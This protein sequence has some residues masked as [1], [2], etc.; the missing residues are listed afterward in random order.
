MA[1]ERDEWEKDYKGAIEIASQYKQE[2]EAVKRVIALALKELNTANS[3]S[4]MAGEFDFVISK[5]H[6]AA[7][8]A[9]KEPT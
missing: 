2:L 7:G 3:C 5:L 1:A 8:A 4:D 6:E 9:Q